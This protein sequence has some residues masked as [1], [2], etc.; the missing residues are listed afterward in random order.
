MKNQG[1]YRSRYIRIN[2]EDEG[3]SLVA[4]TVKNP[5][6]I[7]ETWV[8]FLGGKDALEKQTETHSNKLAWSHKVHGVTKSQAWLSEYHF[9]SENEEIFHQPHDR[10]EGA[11]CAHWKQGGHVALGESTQE[12]SAEGVGMLGPKDA[13]VGG[14]ELPTT[15]SVLV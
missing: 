11:A 4:Q 5:A 2:S 1:S 7:Q 15:L 9:Q 3:A 6:A 13:E 14:E 10:R 12:L 8:W